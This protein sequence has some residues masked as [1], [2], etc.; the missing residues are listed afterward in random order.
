MGH[1]QRSCAPGRPR[2]SSSTS[3]TQPRDFLAAATPG[4][5]KTTF[6]LRLAAELRAR[7]V[8]DRI[9]VVAPDRP[10]QAAVGGCR[11]PRR[12]PARP[13]ASATPTAAAP[14]TSTASPSPTRRS[15]MRPALH[16]E[17][18]LSG[19][20]PRDP[21]RGAPRR[22]RAR[23]GDAIREAFEPRRPSGSRSPAPRSAPTPRPIPFVQ[24]EPDAQGIR[25]LA[26]RLQLRLRPR[27]RRR[28]RAPG[29][30]HGLRR[31][32]ALA[33]EGRRRDGG[34]ARRGQHQ[35]HHLVGV[36]HRARTRAA[37]GSRPCCSAADRRLTE[38]RHGI[39]DAGGLVIATD[40]TAARAYA[41]DPRG[42]QRRARHGRALRREGGERAHR[43][44][45]GRTPAA[46]WS[47]CAWCPRAS[48]CRGSPSASTPPA[49][50]RRCSSRRR[51]AASCGPAVAARRRRSSCRTCRRSW[52]SASQL[53]LERDHAL[54]RRSGERRRRR[55][56]RQPAR[57]REPRGARLRGAARVRHL[58]G[59]RVRRHR[60][61]GCSST[62]PSS[63]RSPSP[64]ATRSSTSSASPACSSP[65]RCRE[66]LRHRQ[67]R[68]ARACGGAAQAHGRPR[69]SRRD[70]AGALP[71]AQGAARRC[72]TASS[73]V[74]A[75]DTG[76]AHSQVH[77]ELRR[78]CGGPAVAQATV[79]QL[80]A[81]IELLRQATR[82]HALV[83]PPR[84]LASTAV[85]ARA[86]RMSAGQV[87]D[88]LEPDAQAHDAG[89][90]L[91]LAATGRCVSEAGCC[92]REST[93]PSETAWVI[94]SQASVNRGRGVVAAGQLDRD[95]SN[96]G[97][98]AG[99]RPGRA[100][101]GRAGPGSARASRRGGR[102]AGAR[103]APGGRLL[104]AHAHAAGCGRP[105]C[106]R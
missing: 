40:Q 51:S 4:A 26:D 94:S 103:R 86:C 21:R 67:A 3:P 78:V 48:T 57:V 20:H 80:Q 66:L 88:V 91:R 49:P 46:G 34:E 2:R 44:V 87:V 93:P 14:A 83:R 84:P 13:R 38:V 30:L 9:T 16:R 7:R 62:A 55:P 41:A 97:R 58:G 73:A 35:G 5:G 27:P 22:R 104:G 36:A 64:A 17:L 29:A 61:T 99:G 56:R 106:S 72:S 98:A 24:Y 53:E 81:R 59:A 43:G 95:E 1:R 69:R 12:H 42:D 102:R 10:P 19:T 82:Q 54:D 100:G 77:A 85:R 39:P 70:A 45:L 74:G 90:R 33:H 105:R 31:P 92:T 50:R 18:T 79:T 89:V 75:A 6:A 11:G 47:P 8:I 96:R 68:Q 76:E 28:R 32:H 37:S 52:R 25:T 63:A 71:H 101:P 15:P 60:S 23:W 65:S